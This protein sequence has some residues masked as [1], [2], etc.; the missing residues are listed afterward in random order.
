M[1]LL[2][3]MK[4]RLGLRTVFALLYDCWSDLLSSEV[5]LSLVQNLHTVTAGLILP[6]ASKFCGNLCSCYS[7]R[8]ALTK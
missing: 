5:W 7:Y 3:V 6:S 2:I 1:H 8:R 4:R